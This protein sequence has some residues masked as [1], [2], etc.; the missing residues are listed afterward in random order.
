VLPFLRHLQID[1]LSFWLGFL[2]ASLFWWLVGLLRPGYK[3]FLAS[4]RTRSQEAR[5]GVA[6]NAEI[7]FRNE[8]LLHVQHQHLASMLFSLDEI[9]VPPRLISP[10]ALTDPGIPPVAEDITFETIPYTPDWPE[11]AAAY[12]SPT[13]SLAEALSG[14]CH[15]VILGAAG[16]GKT[17]ALAHFASLLARQDSQ[18]GDLARCLPVF[19]HIHDLDLTP[20]TPQ[21]PVE[22]L[23]QALG[24]TVSGLAQTR[25]ASILHHA[26]QSGQ[27]VLLIDGLDEVPPEAYQ[28]AVSFIGLLLRQFPAARLVTTAH[29]GYLDGLLGLDFRPVAL[30]AWT[31]AQREAFIKRWSDLWSQYFGKNDGGPETTD[32]LLLNAWLKSSLTSFT[33]LELTLKAWS[34]YAGD[35]LGST[36]NHSL[37]AYIRRMTASN[38]RMRPALEQLA[39]SSML[40]RKDSFTRR[41]AETW[42]AP[43]EPRA[44]Q[45]P[46]PAEPPP[47]QPATQEEPAPEPG[48]A[49]KPAAKEP[50]LTSRLL[51]ALIESGVLRTYSSSRL[52][53]AHPVIQAYLS[54]CHTAENLSPDRLMALPDEWQSKFLVIEYLASRSDISAYV[55]RQL[56][57]DTAP[58]HTHLLSASRWMR[59]APENSPWRS[60]LMRQLASQIQNELNSLAFRAA[61]ITALAVSGNQGVGVLFHQ[62]FSSRLP[63]LRQL[64]ALGCG[65]LR[66][67]KSVSNLAALMNDSVPAVRKA[68]CLA[69]V[70][71]A[72]REALNTVAAALLH[73][74]EELRRA[75]AEALANHPEEGHPTLQDG[76][77][78]EDI[79]V[80]R[81]VAYGIQRVNEPWARELL[82]K[83]QI[84]DQQ[85]IVKNAASQAL[86]ELARPNPHI[87]RR[88]PALTETP[89]LIAFAGERGMG[90]VS[91]KPA[92]DLLLLALKEGSEEQKIAALEYLALHGNPAAV[93]PLY[94]LFYS[95]QGTLRE[96]AYQ[97]LWHFQISDIPLPPPA[98]FG[99]GEPQ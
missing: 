91:G 68:A 50:P 58:L 22:T 32:P 54:G 83:M 84:E 34:A 13:L 56:E 46:R 23:V 81:A 63:G 38:P 5:Q 55:S 24:R 26:L 3:R 36:P 15:L 71:I 76:A 37:E 20:S 10:P 65:L 67:A 40:E 51:P 39:L 4:L 90:V 14:G 31:D 82:E 1:R 93:P 62:L 86:E 11:L 28:P 98:Q 73:G 9:L 61:A 94:N 79:L 16:T 88:Q 60:G 64:A 33:P 12:G 41:E 66:D 85:W 53:F 30:A 87:P 25:L 29:L 72:D 77:A 78:D 21:D 75:A 80:R 52:G 89:W 70:L 57:I 8:V 97:T 92:L 35:M 95:D 43:H 69:L 74:D 6:A 19:F 48:S 99:L 45:S 7:R 44:E 2:A 49:P 27:A 59:L 18:A 47:E 42:I 17:V 96:S